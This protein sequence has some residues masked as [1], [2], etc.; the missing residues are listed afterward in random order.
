L[1]TQDI[2]T[3][4]QFNHYKG[5]GRLEVGYLGI[6]FVFLDGFGQLPHQRLC[7]ELGKKTI[8]RE[9][10]WTQTIKA[11]KGKDMGNKGPIYHPRLCSS[12]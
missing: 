12:L 8:E 6:S 10:P 7:P 9:E 3:Q 1:E 11:N 5:E 2:K 4:P